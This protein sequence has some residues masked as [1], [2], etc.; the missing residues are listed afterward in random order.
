MKLK[1]KLII[2]FT[3][4]LTVFAAV[5]FLITYTRIQRMV[6][7]N[8]EANANAALR[9][10]EGLLDAKYPGD[11]E[12]RD[13]KLYKGNVLINN[14]YELVDEIKK[15]T[16]YLATIFLNDTRIATNVISENGERAMGTKASQEVIDRV[17]ISGNDYIGS[18]IVNGNPFITNYTPIKD[19]ND[20]IIGMWFVGID[21]TTVNA[22]I[23]N[24][25]TYILLGILVVLLIGVFIAYYL[26]HSLTKTVKVVEVHLVEMSQGDFREEISNQYLRLKD[27]I[28]QIA[29]AANHMQK[30][31][32][33]IIGGVFQE[34]DRIDQLLEVSVENISE[35]NSNIENISATIEQLSAGMEETA[36]SM[37]E[38]NA[39]S[40]QIEVAVENMAQRAVE[41]SST[42]QEISTRA[43]ELKL[44][45]QAS[46]DAANQMIKETEAG[47]KG[48]IKESKR[49][50][51]IKILSEVI[52]QI[53]DQTNLLALNAAIEA[54]R[55]GE[56]G[57]GFA[58][59]AE[60]IRK[61]AENSTKAVTEI[62]NVTKNVVEAVEDLIHRSEN[63]LTFMDG[64]VIKDYDMLVQTGERYSDDA[65]YINELVTDFSSTAEELSV[66]ISNMLKAINEVTIATNEGAQGTA[67]IAERIENIVEQGN[68]V[69]GNSKET[70]ESVDKLR[71]KV[72]QLKI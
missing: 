8:F 61:L 42:A 3:I 7:T 39:V 51:E 9:L 67:D 52:L 38:M 33:E 56:A 68:S 66:S 55:A 57:R 12:I 45:T 41:G 48:A 20:N 29:R 72:S 36:S 23:T 13:E 69:V 30:S 24:I 54:A 37:E 16:G 26:G 28:G 53:A 64:Q 5:N 43:F 1:Q 35:Q 31:L 32:K 19:K 60:E 2:S 49:I 46:K 65:Q 22:E 70:K 44:N 58:V 34:T 21:K 14:N 50:D 6:N 47:L 25:I 62:Q 71:E 27:E 17:L 59:V 15:D 63:I 11:W 40:S 10:G 4:V 18:A